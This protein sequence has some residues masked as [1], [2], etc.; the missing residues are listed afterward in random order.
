MWYGC[1]RLWKILFLKEFHVELKCVAGGDG[2]CEFE[3]KPRI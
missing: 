3:V 2:I 1:V